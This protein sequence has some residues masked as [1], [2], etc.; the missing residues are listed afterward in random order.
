M[1]KLLP[2]GQK[3][4]TLETRNANLF[5]PK[6]D[7]GNDVLYFTGSS[8]GQFI[9]DFIYFEHGVLVHTVVWVGARQSGGP[10]GILEAKMQSDSKCHCRKL[11]LGQ[12]PKPEADCRQHP[13]GSSRSR[14]SGTL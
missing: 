4:V 6:S 13:M 8:S 2:K 3:F 5:L 14:D 1:R 12:Q 10:L 11:D 9:P 7:R